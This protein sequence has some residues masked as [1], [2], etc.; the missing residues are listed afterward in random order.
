MGPRCWDDWHD[1]CNWQFIGDHGNRQ[2]HNRPVIFTPGSENKLVK[3]SGWTLPGL[4]P[5]IR[6]VA[7]GG[8]AAVP[9]AVS[10][11]HPAVPWGRA[12]CD[13]PWTH[14]PSRIPKEK[15]KVSLLWAL[16]KWYKIKRWE[17]SINVKGNWNITKSEG[18]LL[19]A[20][21]PG[22]KPCSTDFSHGDF[23]SNR[24]RRKPSHYL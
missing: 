4:W 20:F 23:Q 6:D 1:V 19:S 2:Q 22:Q 5:D 14:C 7:A 10:V 16:W 18:N 15:K 11:V 3:V 24:S 17:K 21:P 8:R 9:V 12:S 13:P